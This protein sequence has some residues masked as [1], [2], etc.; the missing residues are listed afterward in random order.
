VSNGAVGGVGSY[1]RVYGNLRSFQ[2]KT[3]VVAFSVRPVTD[4]NEVTYHSLEV[5][6]HAPATTKKKAAHPSKL[7]THLLLF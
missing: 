1:V 2:G 7:Q 6:H 4:F 5:S 3:N